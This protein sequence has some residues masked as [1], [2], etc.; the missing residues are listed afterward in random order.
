MDAG[1]LFEIATREK[2]RFPSSKGI[3]SLMSE[4]LYEL[5]LKSSNPDVTSL[6]EVAKTL[7]RKLKQS[8]EENFVE[9]DLSTHLNEALENK[10]AIVKHIIKVKLA[11]Q[12]DRENAAVKKERKEKLMALL[13]KKQDAA[14]EELSEEELKKMLDDLG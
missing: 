14:E 1:K 12:A 4:D 7:S 10:F 8:E 3:T 9:L 5:P 2:Y 11:E 6:N 13:L